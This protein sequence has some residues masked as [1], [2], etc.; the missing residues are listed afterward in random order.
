MI[1]DG[2]GSTVASLRSRIA[3]LGRQTNPLRSLAKFA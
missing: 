3:L 1:I 2:L